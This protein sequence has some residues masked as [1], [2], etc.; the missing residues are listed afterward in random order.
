LTAITLLGAADAAL[1]RDAETDT[2]PAFEAGAAG[3]GSRDFVVVDQPVADVLRELGRMQGISV[4]VSKDVEGRVTGRRWQDAPARVLDALIEEYGLQA[5][6][7]GLT[8]HITALAEA[9]TAMLVLSW[10]SAD[11]LA[12]RL[13]ELAIADPR[14]RLRTT[15]D[16]A[17]VRVS[18]PPRFVDL[19]RQTAAALELARAAASRS[20]T[21]VRLGRLQVVRGYA[22]PGGNVP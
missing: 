12:L 3:A 4:A 5:Y 11:E 17:V 15:G 9:Q 19:V 20:P 14:Y 16:G 13:D 6:D 8:L 7:D 1:A 2:A 10:T 21:G 22:V 18:G